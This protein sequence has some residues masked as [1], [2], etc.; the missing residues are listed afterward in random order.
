MPTEQDF[1]SL[2]EKDTQYPMLL[3]HWI[4]LIF[5][6]LV[7]IRSLLLI[8]NLSTFKK[9]TVSKQ[10]GQRKERNTMPRIKK[11]TVAVSKIFSEINTDSISPLNKFSFVKNPT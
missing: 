9:F 11:K 2:L 6:V 10:K 3:Q 5:S 7:K 8:S 1:Q 4:S